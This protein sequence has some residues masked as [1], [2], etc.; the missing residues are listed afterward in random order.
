MVEGL[1]LP[2]VAEHRRKAADEVGKSLDV[3]GV[4]LQAGGLEAHCPN[5]VDNRLG[6]GRS[7]VIGDNDVAALARDIESSVVAKAAAATGNKRDLRH[8]WSP[9]FQGETRS[10]ERRVGQEWVSTCRSRWS[11]FN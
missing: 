1:S 9:R 4:E 6:V 11:P 7:T 10:E 5:L 2:E 3:P 8:E